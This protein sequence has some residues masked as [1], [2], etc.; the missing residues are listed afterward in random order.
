MSAGSATDVETSITK[1]TWLLVLA[2]IATSWLAF[3]IELGLAMP[4]GEQGPCL[5][6]TQVVSM[7]GDLTVHLYF[8]TGDTCDAGIAA[9]YPAIAF[10]HGFSMFGLSNG[11]SDNQGNGEHLASWGY[12][13]AI[14]ELPDDFEG[15]LTAMQRVLSYLETQAASEGSVLYRR[16]DAARLAAAGHSLG[17]ATAL[18]LTSR[19]SRIRAVVA[20]DP[21]YHTGGFGGE[22]EALW[23]PEADAPLIAVPAGILGAPARSCNAG[24]D[25]AD[26]YPWVGA[27][28]KA[29]YTL[30]G[31]SHCDF[32]DPGN[33]FCGLI[34]GPA[35]PARTDLS[36]K[37]MTAWFNY[38]LYLR[39]NEHT[40]LYGPESDADVDAGRIEREVD[41]APRDLTASGAVE[42]IRL[43][44][45]PH[46]HPIVAGYNVYRRS[47]G[48]DFGETSYGQVGWTGAYTD[49]DVVVGQTYSYTVRSRDA[50]GN[51]HEPADEVSAVAQ[52][53]ERPRRL[54]YLPLVLRAAE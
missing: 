46:E 7:D 35:D 2:I 13:V 9:P 25:Y 23:D 36:Q 29:S 53:G 39:V 15:R 5:T 26:I 20:L 22:G 47:S 31:G 6:S 33:R 32:N 52:D 12:V 17:G 30:A 34:C 16:V 11:A 28:H 41:T 44:W 14:P 45:T 48:A 37:Y 21:V 51:V 24:A 43:E 50:G 42:A 27:T 49:G 38:Y 1:R 54:F 18:V 8:P 19:D 10:A 3:G 40:Y 4:P